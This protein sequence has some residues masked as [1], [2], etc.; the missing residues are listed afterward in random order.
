[1]NKHEKVFII[2]ILRS[3]KISSVKKGLKIDYI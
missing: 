1:M 2:I 3:L